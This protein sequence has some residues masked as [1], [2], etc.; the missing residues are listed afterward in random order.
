MAKRP[1]TPALYVLLLWLGAAPFLLA[2]WTLHNQAQG[3]IHRIL[4]DAALVVAA[5]LVGLGLLIYWVYVVCLSVWFAY[6]PDS[7]GARHWFVRRKA[8]SQGPAF[9]FLPPRSRQAPGAAPPPPTPGS[10]NV[11][12]ARRADH[13][14]V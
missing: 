2:A 14:E 12:R 1:G 7:Q 11:P 6:D 10:E 8:A 4:Y 9:A 13:R 5:L 3:A